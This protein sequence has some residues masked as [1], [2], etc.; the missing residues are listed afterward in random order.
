[1]SPV[2]LQIT[3]QKDDVLITVP[4][5]PVINLQTVAIPGFQV[6]LAG[7]VG[8]PGPQGQWVAL[9]QAEYD[10]LSPPDPN[11]LYVIVE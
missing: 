4:P 10:A 3:A 11:I 8:P 2:S 7:N 1:M 5:K 9:T 6:V